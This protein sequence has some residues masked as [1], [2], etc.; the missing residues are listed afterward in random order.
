MS[1]KTC[2]GWSIYYHPL[3]VDRYTKLEAKVFN[4]KAKLPAKKFRHHETARLYAAIV[5]IVEEKIPKDPLSEHFSLKYEL[6][7]YCR[8]KG[9]GLDERHRLF[10]KVFESEKLIIVLWLG[11]PR[12]KR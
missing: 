3:F 2:N 11:Y 12:K 7:D 9:M 8:V 10:F 1:S 4:L 5:K 6:V